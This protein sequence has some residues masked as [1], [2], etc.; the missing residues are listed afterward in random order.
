MF[1]WRQAFDVPLFVRQAGVEETVVESGR[2]ALPK[3]DGGWFDAITAPEGWEGDFAVVE[4]AADF[5][6][7]L[8]E[9][10]P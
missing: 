5:V 6:E 10:F 1:S 8:D 3:F 4:F 9:E 7:F 2:A